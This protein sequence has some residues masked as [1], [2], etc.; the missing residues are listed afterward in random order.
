MEAA[1]FGNQPQGVPSQR[2]RE[3]PR[4]TTTEETRPEAL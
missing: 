1:R 4:A 3:G 2:N